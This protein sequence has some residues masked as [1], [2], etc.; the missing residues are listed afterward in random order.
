LSDWWFLGIIFGQLPIVSGGFGIERGSGGLSFVTLS[1]EIT[2]IVS[3]LLSGIG[4]FPFPFI[5]TT[6]SLNTMKIKQEKR[7]MAMF[8]TCAHTYEKS[9]AKRKGIPEEQWDKERGEHQAHLG[10][11]MMADPTPWEKK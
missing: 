1:M 10:A 4:F 3:Y 2:R 9:K 5:K 7:E 6:W 8:N 11:I